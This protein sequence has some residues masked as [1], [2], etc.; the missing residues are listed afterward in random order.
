MNADELLKQYAA[1]ARNFPGVTL[2]GVCLYRA[3][4]EKINLEW[5]KRSWS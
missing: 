3:I 2:N 4:L 1:G 5:R